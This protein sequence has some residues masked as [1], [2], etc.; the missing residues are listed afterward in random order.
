MLKIERLAWSLRIESLSASQVL[1][2]TRELEERVKEFRT[3]PLK[4]EYA[5]S[6]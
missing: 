4:A 5:S 2:I 6:G 3:R 1:E